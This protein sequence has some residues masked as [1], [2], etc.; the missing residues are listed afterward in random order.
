MA[1]Q[2]PTDRTHIMTITPGT[3]SRSSA[4]AAIVAGLIFIGVQLGHPHLDVA[5]VGS[6]E[7]AVR[8]AAK[9]VFATLALAGITGMYLRQVKQMGRLGLVAYLLLATGYLLITSTALVAGYVLP[10]LVQTDPAYVNGVLA[11]AAGGTASSDIGLIETA[12]AAEGITYL[13][14]GLLFGIALYRARVLARWGAVLLAAGAVF[15][16]ALSVLPDSYYRLLAY[17]NAAALI[18]LGYSLWR[19]QQTHNDPAPRD[20]VDIAPQTRPVGAK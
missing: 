14:G 19:N 4:V 8:N 11:V 6:T 5:S 7:W 3:L 1:P 2:S 10:S 9:M 15:T 16:L 20:G 17:P 12:L 18:V 13:A